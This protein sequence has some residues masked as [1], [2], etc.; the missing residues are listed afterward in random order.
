[1]YVAHRTGLKP[2]E[3]DLTV[4]NVLD[5]QGWDEFAGTMRVGFAKQFPGEAATDA[6]AKGFRELQGM[7]KNF[8]WGM[9][10]IAPR[11]VGP[12]AWNPDERKQTQIRRRFM[13]L[14]QTRD[15]M[16]IWDVRRAVKAL[17][18]VE[19]FAQVPLWLQGKR[20]AAGL[21]L[22]AA[23][24]EPSVVRVD[25][26]DLPRSHHEGPMLLNVLRFL[27]VPTT[28]ALVGERADVRIYQSE[29]GGWEYPQAVA[30][31]LGWGEKRVQVRV[32]EE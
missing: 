14:G 3:L 20:E 32:V 19:G 25:L 1:M 24:F 6:D 27:D 7:L 26:W 17:G 31:K 22:Y 15:G 11:G 23:L 2:A 13:L 4:L 9:A 28:A 10:W 12:T 8:K 30:R 5:E 18:S 29:A 21:A 16:R